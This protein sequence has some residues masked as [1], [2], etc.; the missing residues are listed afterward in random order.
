M[1]PWGEADR[2]GAM[3]TE[4]APVTTIEH[5]HSVTR[6]NID[7]TPRACIDSRG[8]YWPPQR[9]LEVLR[10]IGEGGEV[11]QP[12]IH[13]RFFR[14]RSD[15]VLSRAIQKL[16]AHGLL[17]IDRWNKVGVNRLRLTTAGRTLLHT[18]GVPE[19]AIFLLRKAV[20]PA[21][22]S[23]TAWI[24]DLRVVVAESERRPVFALPAWALQRLIRPLPPTIPDLLVH[25]GADGKPA[26]TI[27]FEVDLGSERL[28]TVFV[29]KLQLLHTIMRSWSS[30]AHIIIVLTAGARRAALL[31]AQLSV[32]ET[33]A[34]IIVDTLPAGSGRQAI[35]ALRDRLSFLR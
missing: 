6:F 13:E 1:A 17:V 35:A 3:T 26:L 5:L 14:G 16:A 2:N 20:A 21:H 34:G 8:S 29:P 11:T 32:H 22:A 12:Q 25:F 31:R 33:S 24:N 4:I 23:H 18:A 19:H 30:G 10:F 28:R 7:H 15:A 27:A 9:S